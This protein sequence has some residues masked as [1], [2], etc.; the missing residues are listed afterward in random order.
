M[1]NCCRDGECQIDVL[2]YIDGSGDGFGGWGRKFVRYVEGP[3]VLIDAYREM[4]DTVPKLSLPPTLH[5]VRG[6]GSFWVR[7]HIVIDLDQVDS[8]TSELWGEHGADLTAIIRNFLR[9]RRGKQISAHLFMWIA[10]AGRIIA[11]E[12]GHALDHAGFGSPYPDNPEHAADWFAARLDATRGKSRLVGEYVFW[13]V[14]CRELVCDFHG[15]PR[16]RLMIYRR[17]YLKAA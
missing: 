15:R 1:K 2:G 14:G 12:L 17:G 7:G 16:T 9:A 5:F 13:A 8:I 6:G 10:V 4:L 11:H 3:Q